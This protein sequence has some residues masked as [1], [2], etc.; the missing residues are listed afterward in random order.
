MEE[1]H[2]GRQGAKVIR[3]YI[4]NLQPGQVTQ[5]LEVRRR[6][7]V[8]GDVK[9]LKVRERVGLQFQMI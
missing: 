6:N 5:L 4:K 3:G 7:S 1:A 9:C 2:V 8:V